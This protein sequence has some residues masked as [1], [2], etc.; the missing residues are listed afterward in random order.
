MTTHRYPIATTT[1]ESRFIS[2]TRAS[3][4][5]G[6][7]PEMILE[8]VRAGLVPL[9]AP[10]PRSGTQDGLD[11]SALGRLHQIADLRDDQV[12]LRTVRYIMRLLD[13]LET[14]EHELRILRERLR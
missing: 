2:L 12:N 1:V 8:F 14:A 5:T 6:L 4:L 13:R 3:E 11:E 7:H 10:H 9:A